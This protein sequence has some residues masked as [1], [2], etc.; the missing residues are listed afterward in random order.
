ME[1]FIGLLVLGVIAAIVNGISRSVQRINASWE[2]A[3]SR[4]GL[5]FQP[6]TTFKRRAVRGIR[7]AIHVDLSERSGGNNNA[8]R[9]WRLAYPSTPFS[10]TLTVETPGKK[11]LKAFGAQ[12][13]EIGDPG[14]DSRFMVAGSDRQGIQ[15]YLTQ[16]RRSALLEAAEHLSGLKVTNNDITWRTN[17][18]YK[19]SGDLIDDATRLLRLASVMAGEEVGPPPSAVTS[20]A[21]PLALDRPSADPWLSAH[22]L[23]PAEPVPTDSQPP[24]VAETSSALP[25]DEMPALPEPMSEP[26]DAAESEEEAAKGPPVDFEE[27]IEDVFGTR[28]LSYEANQL[29]D[30]RYAGRGMTVL[31]PVRSARKSDR[32]FDFREEGP[33]VRVEAVVGEVTGTR[34]G[35]GSVVA[36]AHLPAGTP[37]P[38]RGNEVLITGTIHKVETLRRAI[39]LVDAQLG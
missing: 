11:L 14:F 36:I 12:D 28:R 35:A 2:E 1:V 16:E 17:N 30:Q 27:L 21:A 38:K 37:L 19:V 29:V 3:A 8:V 15:N 9:Q 4:L 18:Q 25:Q 24:L 10:M 39:Y 20:I 26:D 6:G 23:P 13:F 5:D 34:V 7:G 22:L 32:D 31:G 33:G